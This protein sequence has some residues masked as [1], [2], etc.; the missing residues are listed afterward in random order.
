MP[1]GF[2]KVESIGEDKARININGIVGDWYDGNTS[3]DVLNIIENTRVTDIEVVIQSPGGS[4][5]EGIAIYNA[6]KKHPAKVTTVVLGAAA[7][8]A[9]IIFMAGDERIM[10][11]NTWLMIH[12]PNL[13]I[14]GKAKELR[15]AADFLDSLTTSLLS[16]YSPYINIEDD[17]LMDLIVAETWINAADAVVMGFA[18]SINAELKAVALSKD[19]TSRFENLPNAMNHNTIADTISAIDNIKDFEKV[20]RESGCSRSMATALVVKA[21]QLLQSE[22]ETD[23]DSIFNHLTTFKLN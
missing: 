4:A 12:E 2:F 9:S 18:T 1:K 15:E 11:S 6:L 19:F 7:S 14:S 23:L 13:M 22:S 3:M 16:T 5:F 20:L 8:A 21:K 17:A 10:P